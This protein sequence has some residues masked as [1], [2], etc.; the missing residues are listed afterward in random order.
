M[1][2]PRSVKSLCEFIW[3]LEE[4]FD[5]MSFEIEGVRTWQYIRME[6]YYTL[7]YKLQIFDAPSV[8]KT[9]FMKV[10]KYI[11]LLYS[12]IFHNPLGVKKCD[13]LF[14]ASGGIKKIGEKYIDIYTSGL[15]DKLSE[16]KTVYEFRLSSELIDSISV[17]S[18]NKYLDFILLHSFLFGRRKKLDRNSMT[19]V[20]TLEKYIVE[21]LGISLN[22]NN[23]FLGKVKNFLSH[24]KNYIKILKKLNP[25]RIYIV[26]SYGFYAPLIDAAKELSIE[27]VELQ[28]GTFSQYHLGYS[29]PVGI[30]EIKYFPNK[31]FVWNA[32]WKDFIKLP[33]EHNNLIISPSIY[34][35][36]EKEKYEKLEKNKDQVVIL[37]QGALSAQIA[38][39]VLKYWNFF[40]TKQLKYK[41]HP[42][43]YTTWKNNT[44]VNELRKYNNVEV[45]ED[46]DLYRLLATSEI[47]VGVFSTAIYEGLEF[48]CETILLDLPGIEY[49]QKLVETSYASMIE[50][51]MKEIKIV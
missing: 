1:K 43:E 20:F 41:L 9:P 3:H 27:T 36:K 44:Y 28:H 26:Q 48:N 2:K 19:K 51:K 13:V 25:E 37:S 24:K 21:T 30:E 42:S 33:I 10:V 46:V 4:K 35:K 7:A 31:F 15:I 47:Q 14:F 50:D 16:D 12:S 29:F 22:L 6:I 5:L 23:V 11:K 40:K 39:E 18:S 49:M 32:F 17:N 8:Q 45:L 38:E 34:M